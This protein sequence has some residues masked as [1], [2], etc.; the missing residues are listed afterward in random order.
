M[1]ETGRRI[2]GRNRPN[3]TLLEVG[4]SED[5]ARDVLEKVHEYRYHPKITWAGT[6]KKTCMIVP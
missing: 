5:A 4:L 6:R 3:A 1:P 2:I